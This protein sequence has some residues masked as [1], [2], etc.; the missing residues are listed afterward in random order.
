MHAARYFEYLLIIDR[1]SFAFSAGF[2]ETF[3][4]A[5]Q[6]AGKFDPA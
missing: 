2:F 1:W 5:K 3:L 6:G 4:T